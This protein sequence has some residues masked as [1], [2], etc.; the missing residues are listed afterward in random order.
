MTKFNIIYQ[1][2]MQENELNNKEEQMIQ[3]EYRSLQQFKHFLDNLG[4]LTQFLEQTT[5]SYII[6]LYKLLNNTKQYFDYY[7]KFNPHY[8]AENKHIFQPL[9]KY[10][11][12][13]NVTI[14]GSKDSKRVLY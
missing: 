6:K 4:L 11:E 8:Y 7:Y 5:T 14:D 2:Y 10:K 12:K 1:Q 3:K 9:I 13:Y